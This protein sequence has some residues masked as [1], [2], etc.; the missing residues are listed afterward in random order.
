[1]FIYKDMNKMH[2]RKMFERLYDAVKCC[3]LILGIYIFAEN[4][5]W[6]MKLKCFLLLV[7]HITTVFLFLTG[8]FLCGFLLEG[9][10]QE[11]LSSVILYYSALALRFELYRRRNNIKELL[12]LLSSFRLSKKFYSELK[13]I[14][15]RLYYICI[16]P[17]V[18]I[19]ILLVSNLVFLMENAPAYMQ[20]NTA[21]HMV[22]KSINLDL[23]MYFIPS[24]V[25]GTFISSILCSFIF[26]ILYGT[27]S[28]HMKLILNHT[29]ECIR[30]SPFSFKKNHLI[31]SKASNML[32][33]MNNTLSKL[34]FLSAFHISTLLYYTI[35][36]HLRKGFS[37]NYNEIVSTLNLIFILFFFSWAISFAAEIPIVNDAILKDILE[38][39]FNY[40]SFG[41][42]LVLTQHIQKGL[43]LTVNG[44]FPIKKGTFLVMFGTIATYSLMVKSL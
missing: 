7:Y 38:V 39:P 27:A 12:K 3:F 26:F 19:T 15:R 9:I 17:I 18:L 21:F 14:R 44:M 11:N 29:R 6:G 42:R 31:Y 41:E 1:M 33:S 10:N 35:F 30:I 4:N 23:R 16:I 13:K 22:L 34:L 8:F 2:P 40:D 5:K 24:I 43:Y 37:S 36:T 25:F 28:W 32:D 20:N